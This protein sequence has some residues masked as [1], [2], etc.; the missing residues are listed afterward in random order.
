V[1][2]TPGQ[3]GQLGHIGRYELIA[4]L[5]AGGMGEVFRARSRGAGGFEKQVVIKRILPHL[6]SDPDFVQRFIEEGKLVVKLRHAGIVQVLD[7]GEQDGTFFIAMEHVDGKDLA[8]LLRASKASHIALP[9]PI[10]VYMLGELLEALDYAHRATDVDGTPLGIIHRDVSPSNVLVSQTGEVKLVDFGIARATE[11]LAATTTGA[12]RGKYGYM[13]PQQAAGAELDARSDLFSVGVVAWE[14]LSGARPFDGA[15]D[16]LTLDRVRFHDPGAL[17]TVAPT[18]PEDLS[19]W[20]A[21]LLAKQPEDRFAS[22]DEAMRALREHVI[23]SR[24]MVG[25]RELG[26]WVTGVVAALP[27]GLR[28]QSTAGLS[29]DDVLRL[30]L[31]AGPAGPLTLDAAPRTP[32]ASG[33]AGGDLIAA[34]IPPLEIISRPLPTPV[35]PLPEPLTPPRS[36]RSAFM[37]AL[38]VT[39]VA[40]IAVVVFALLRDSGSTP[41]DTAD[42]RAATEVAVASATTMTPDTIVP[43]TV[44]AATD[45]TSPAPPMESGGGI[46][47]ALAD[48]GNTLIGDDVAVVVKAVP[49]NATVVIDGLGALDRTKPWVVRRGTLLEARVSATDHATEVVHFTAGEDVPVV[50]LGK[51]APDPAE[52]GNVVFRFRPAN[53]LVSIDGKPVASQG[54]A[55][56]KLALAVGTHEV[57]ISDGTHRLA[58]GFAI[59]AG[60]DTVLGELDATN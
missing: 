36:K 54:R 31:G 19:R 3:L 45:V 28:Q 33:R 35:T 58:R 16:L 41:A 47:A 29:L 39:N 17:A 9:I 37:A 49:A 59:E 13:S 27:V 42:A 51:K 20:V 32:S 6:A 43:E 2:N 34:A 11:R 30:G 55:T 25:A 14:L 18:V 48:L 24:I 8:E 10:A 12:I 23:E 53:A 5:G 15:S 7:M 56:L 4:R 44:L 26:E 60:K 1:T 21:R 50:R 46:G 38:L 57:V 22:A 40:L 52:L